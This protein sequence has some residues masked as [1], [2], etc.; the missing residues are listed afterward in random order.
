MPDPLEYL[1]RRAAAD[2]SFLA[3]ALA[4]FART[5]RLNDQAL[6]A[7][8]GCPPDDLNALRLCR[9]PAAD[10]PAFRRDI[11]R[12]AAAFGLKADVLAEVL[13]RWR[14]LGCLRDGAGDGRGTLLAARDQPPPRKDEG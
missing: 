12:I 14:A 5:E 4:A 2:P 7:A 11:D 13:T 3:A 8:L 1:A 6:A 10:P 9:M